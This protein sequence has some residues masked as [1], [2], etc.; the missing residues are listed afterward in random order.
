MVLGGGS[1]IEY[2]ANFVS[3]WCRGMIGFG[4]LVYGDV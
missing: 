4:G 3:M 2:V 1:R